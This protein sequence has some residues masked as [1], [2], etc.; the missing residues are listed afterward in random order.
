MAD[1]KC[2]PRDEIKDGLGNFETFAVEI[3]AISMMC[4]DD[5]LDQ[6]LM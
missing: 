2:A 3:V 5:I 4:L 6:I 1:H